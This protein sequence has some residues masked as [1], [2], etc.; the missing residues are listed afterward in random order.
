MTTFFKK[1]GVVEFGFI[2]ESYEKWNIFMQWN[3]YFTLR[4][5]TNVN[6]SWNV[7]RV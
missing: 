3:L 5:I 4:H 2:I 7:H 6:V 1:H